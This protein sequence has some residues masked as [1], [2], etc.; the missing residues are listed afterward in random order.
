MALQSFPRIYWRISAIFQKFITANRGFGVKDGLVVPLVAMPN[1]V[2]TS[3]E[4]Y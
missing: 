3:G 2:V 4:V 1:R